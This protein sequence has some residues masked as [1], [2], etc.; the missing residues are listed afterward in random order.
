MSVSLG[1]PRRGLVFGHFFSG[2]HGSRQQLLHV[3]CMPYN[4]RSILCTW[5][6]FVIHLLAYCLRRTAAT[7]G[8]K[9][10][11]CDSKTRARAIFTRTSLVVNG[12][13]NLGGPCF[14]GGHD[15]GTP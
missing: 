7:R 6:V 8:K 13:H 2:P 11:T 5:H 12:F 14:A 4:N 1:V 10:N 9:I 15:T 3:Y